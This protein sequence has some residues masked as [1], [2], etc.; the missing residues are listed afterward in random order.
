MHSPTQ[1]MMKAGLKQYYPCQHLIHMFKTT[2]AVILLE[3]FCTWAQEFGMNTT[4]T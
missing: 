2:L 4:G 3:K 1:F